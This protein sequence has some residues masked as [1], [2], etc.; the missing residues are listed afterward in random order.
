M[1][2]L[3][4]LPI[5]L[6]VT[7][8]FAFAIALVLIATGAFIYF[9]VGAE[10]DSTIDTGLE[11][12]AAELAAAVASNGSGLRSGARFETDTGEGFSQV[13]DS[14]A[15][16]VDGT[17]GLGNRPLL[18]PAQLRGATDGAMTVDRVTVQG[19]EGASRLLVLPVTRP[20][21][22]R[23]AVVG[24]SLDDRDDALRGLLVQLLIGGPLALTLA[25]LLG[26]AVAAAALRP[27]E[28]MR[29]EAAAISASEPGRR[30]SIPPAQDEV[31][32]LGETLNEL[33]DRLEAAL[34]RERTFVADASHE[35]RAPLALLRT[36]LELALRRPRSP[37][38]LEA[39][40][41]SASDESD[42]LVQLAEDLLVL[43]RSDQGRLPLRTGRIAARVVV[44]GVADRFERRAQSGERTISVD[45]P[46]G[47]ELVGD[48]LRL[49]Q[50]L[51]N[52][53]ENAFRH[54]EGPVRI[55]ADELDGRVE[56]HVTDE[57]PGF[58][59]P[60]LANAFERFTRADE[61]RSRGGAGLGLAIVA[62]IAHAHGGTAAAANR[63]PGGADVWISI[64]ARD[65]AGRQSP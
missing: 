44:G 40:L 36:E 59:Q 42:R 49:E 23:F 62:V 16:I 38:E 21:G 60:F 48:R 10:L 8:A 53:V 37:E 24:A 13:L 19:V 4:E 61:A 20:E 18:S 63:E 54:G 1:P 52:L 22:V 46:D 55:S 34:A 15:H 5:R 27:V 45:V 32:R 11:S 2:A 28:S 3:N 6:R 35:L 50:A 57:G 7:L 26:Y 12:R 58:P 39:A 56:L 64:P 33:L 51:G 9:R 31:A 29:R 17:P 47:L 43:A 30:L 41:R 14:S 65:D 25:S